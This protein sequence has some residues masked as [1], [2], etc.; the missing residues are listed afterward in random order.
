MQR[1]AKPRAECKQQQL[2]GSFAAHRNHHR[3]SPCHAHSMCQPCDLEATYF[4][5]SR[6]LGHCY[7][8]VACP[9]LSLLMQD[10]ECVLLVTLVLQKSV[11]FV[12]LHHGHCRSS[13]EVQR[14]ANILP[15]QIKLKP[16]GWERSHQSH[17]TIQEVF[18]LPLKVNLTLLTMLQ[19]YN[20]FPFT[21][22]LVAAPLPAHFCSISNV[23][24][25]KPLSSSL[26][27]PLIHSQKL[28]MQAHELEIASKVQS[29][30]WVCCRS[31]KHRYTTS[32][33]TEIHTHHWD[34]KLQL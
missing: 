33:S 29:Q 1:A 34:F 31:Q 6:P 25:G 12:F 7:L 20:I 14:F 28:C 19:L 23:L 2:K 18:S 27:L 15:P 26:G 22:F 21:R 24:L 4:T 32:S 8:W 9:K 3:S 30:D 5:P 11:L 16:H 13:L 17:V 10:F